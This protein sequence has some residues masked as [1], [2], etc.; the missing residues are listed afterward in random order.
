[1]LNKIYIQILKKRIRKQLLSFRLF[2]NSIKKF[3]QCIG[4]EKFMMFKKPTFGAV[5]VVV[6]DDY[7]SVHVCQYEK[8][9]MNT[10]KKSLSTPLKLMSC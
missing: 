3:L 5:V 2:S 8:Q 6:D 1:M 9:K 10:S 7:F 4:R